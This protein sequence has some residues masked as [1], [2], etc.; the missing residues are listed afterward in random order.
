MVIDY[1]KAGSNQSS[2]CSFNLFFKNIFIILNNN[3]IQTNVKEKR[4]RMKG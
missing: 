3:K 2:N 1:I 4:K